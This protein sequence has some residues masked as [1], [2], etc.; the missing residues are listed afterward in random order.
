[1]DA[2]EAAR[3]EYYRV[4]AFGNLSDVK[5]ARHFWH[6]V[7]NYTY[8]AEREAIAR[9][10]VGIRRAAEYANTGQRA[11]RQYV[12]ENEYKAAL[13]GWQR[14]LAEVPSPILIV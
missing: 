5:K 3:A 6:T 14:K 11:A 7:V 13:A 12:L 4:L 1:M 10:W 8:S 9:E 2:I